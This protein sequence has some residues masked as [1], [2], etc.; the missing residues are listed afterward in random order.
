MARLLGF[1]AT[2]VTIT[3]GESA[4]FSLFWEAINTPSLDYTVF[5][6]LLDENDNIVASHDSQPLAGRYP[7]SIWTPGERI[8][9]PHPLPTPDSLPPGQYRLAIGLYYQ[10]TGERLPLNFANNG[11]DSEG[12]LILQQLVAVKK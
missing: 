1:E 10:P 6:H 7:T 8:L 3:A 9:D 2:Q 5:V 11:S 12:R 4:S